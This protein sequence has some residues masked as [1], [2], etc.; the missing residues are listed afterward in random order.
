MQL[1]FINRFGSLLVLFCSL[2]S[3]VR[4]APTDNQ[5][6]VAT[7][8]T[9]TNPIIAT[10]SMADPDVL[11]VDGKYYLYPTS[12]NK[13]YEVYVSDD[14]VH[15]ENKGLV[16][17]D[18]R[19]GTWAPDV[20]RSSRNGN[21][22]YLYYT[23][24]SPVESGNRLVGRVKQIGVAEAESPLGPFEDKAILANDAIDAHLFEDE[25]GKLYLYY[26]QLT[27]GFKILVQPMQD[28][29]TPEGK[30][31]EVIRPTEPW[32]MISGHVTEGPFML[33]RGDI[34]YLMYS[35]TGADSP[36][37]GIGYA[38]A[39]SPLGPFTKYAGNPIANRSDSLLGPG[40]H[41]VVE[42]PDGELWMLYHQK[43]DEKTN[44]RR[45]LCL[46]R[47]WFDDSGVLHA[48]VTRGT[49]EPS[50]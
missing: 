19:G 46:D 5:D 27:G 22:Y 24:N 34:Y 45:D 26:V 31:T 44:F 25:D 40:H 6:S 17:D 50:P 28:P 13:G 10:P 36:N 37:Y 3:A 39:Q 8:E 14:L 49:A 35:G 43:L 2:L 42:G 16:F 7:T 29:L 12:H 48:K 20:F 18:P 9:Y 11:L 15:W 47:L 1:M 41:C 30:P 21:K 38:T 32:E 23:D 33:K 4:A